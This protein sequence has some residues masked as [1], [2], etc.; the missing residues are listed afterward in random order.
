M[1]AAP[2]ET[3]EL[4]QQLGFNQLEAEVYV[5]LLPNPPQTAYRIGKQ[6]DRATANVYKA[7]DSLARKG[8]VVVESTSDG[9]RLGRAVPVADFFRLAERSFVEKTKRAA[10]MLAN[11]QAAPEEERVYHIASVDQVL[12]RCREMLEKRASRIAVIDAFPKALQ[13]ILPSIG[14]AIARNVAVYVEAY[15]PVEIEGAN[16]VLAHNYS[17]V[18]SFWRSEQLNVVVD[19]REHLLALLSEDLSQLHV[20]IWSQGLYLSCLAHAGRLC[21]HTLQRLLGAKGEA[22]MRKILAEHQFFLTSNVPGQQELMARHIR[23]G[24]LPSSDK[25]KDGV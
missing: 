6:L 10:E 9:D 12:H 13:A 18:E 19:G 4:L 8:A 21:E 3:I 16:V 14:A 7:V 1:A 15:A 22:A 25:E 20:G 5:F 11:L 24:A 2:P 17:Q 23:P